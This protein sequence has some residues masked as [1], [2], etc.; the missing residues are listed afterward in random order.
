MTGLIRM[1]QV[2]ALGTD[3]IMVRAEPP[4][5]G[6]ERVLVRMAAAALNFADLL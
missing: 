5:A 3:P 2:E 4:A 6:R 1:A